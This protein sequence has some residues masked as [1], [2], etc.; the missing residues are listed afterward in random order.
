MV[1]GIGSGVLYSGYTAYQ[2]N[3]LENRIEEF[4]FNPDPEV[5]N[6]FVSEN[7]HLFGPGV[8]D[9]IDDFSR[10]PENETLIDRAH[11]IIEIWSNIVYQQVKQTPC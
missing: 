8:Y 2:I 11:L 6:Q 9:L 1:C 7:N 3:S 4:S 10:N 5:F